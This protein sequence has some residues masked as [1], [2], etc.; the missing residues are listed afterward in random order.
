MPQPVSTVSDSASEE[1]LETPQS[2]VEALDTGFL[3]D[4]EHYRLTGEFETPANKDDAASSKGKEKPSSEK[5]DASAASR[6]QETQEQD[7][8]SKA[9]ASAT[10]PTQRT[11]QTSQRRESRWEKRERELKTLR[12][13]NARLKAQSSQGPQRSETRQEEVTRPAAETEAEAGKAAAK[14]KIDDI[15]PK[16]QK[17]KYKTFAEYEDAKDAWLRKETIREF[18]ESNAKTQQQQERTVIDRS[19]AEQVDKFRETHADYDQVVADALAETDA[20]GRNPIFYTEGSHIDNFLLSQPDRGAGLLYHLMKNSSDPAVRGIFARTPDGTRYQL[21]MIEQ[22]SRL[23]V[24]AH[25]LAGKSSSRTSSG[26]SQ[27]S[28]NESDETLSSARPVTRASRPPHQVS[29][30]GTVAKDAVEQALEDG[31]FETYSRTQNAK[32]IARQKRK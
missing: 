14:P 7:D 4:D 20:D 5:H 21:T 10:A 27:T 11:D 23:G 28:H 29:G 30:Q 2:L 18:N 25:T 15:D 32:E 9:A 26:T 12:E 17:P 13:E 22:I 24:L 6:T 19:R 31:D 16:T 8:A 3:P 1:I